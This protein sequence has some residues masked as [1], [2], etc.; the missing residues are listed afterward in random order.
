MVTAQIKKDSEKVHATKET[1]RS[2]HPWRTVLK[3]EVV[4]GFKTRECLH[5]QAALP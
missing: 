3:N 1:G 2:R 4:F 5:Q